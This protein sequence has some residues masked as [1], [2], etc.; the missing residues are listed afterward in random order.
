MV[1]MQLSRDFEVF[2]RQFFP[3]DPLIEALQ[4]MMQDCLEQGLIGWIN[5]AAAY[6]AFV[7][8]DL[9]T[10]AQRLFRAWAPFLGLPDN[11]ATLLETTR[12]PEP[13][14]PPEAATGMAQGTSQEEKEEEKDRQLDDSLLSTSVSCCNERG[15]QLAVSPTEPNSGSI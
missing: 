15:S 4:V 5:V 10:G 3:D 7:E 12:E 6:F 13:P 11:P 2:L 9:L 14:E 1:S 8:G